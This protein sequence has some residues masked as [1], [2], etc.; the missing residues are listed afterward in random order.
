[1]K[2]AI[3]LI[4]SRCRKA[5]NNKEALL[6]ETQKH[7]EN[8]VDEW[9]SETE[10]CKTNKIT[11]AYQ[12][13]DRGYSSLLCDFDR[14]DRGLWPTLQSMRNVENTALIKLL[15]GVRLRDEE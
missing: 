11:M 3:S 14:Q 1:M 9:S 15:G 2:N 4:K 13:K 6:I 8:L 7:I 10:Y 5:L 12:S